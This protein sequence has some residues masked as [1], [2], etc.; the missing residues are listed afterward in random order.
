MD[1]EWRERETCLVHVLLSVDDL[2]GLV[3]RPSADVTGV[4]PPALVD[5]LTSFRLV[6]E[7]AFEHGTA[8]NTDLTD[9]VLGEVVLFGHVDELDVI[10][11]RGNTGLTNHDIIDRLRAA[12]DTLRLTVAFDEEARE[13]GTTES[14]HFG[15]QRSTG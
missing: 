7:V 15:R 6:F 11:R 14:T 8:T 4:Q 13:C 2:H 12:D 10:E 3:R 9:T 1:Q 5:R